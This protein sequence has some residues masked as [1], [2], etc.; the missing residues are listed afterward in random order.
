MSIS[1]YPLLRSF[2]GALHKLFLTIPDNPT[3]KINNV[4]SIYK[5]LNVGFL[6]EKEIETYFGKALSCLEDISLPRENKQIMYD[7]VKQLLG[8]EL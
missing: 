7:V 3:E 2:P 5:D 4:L 6:V 1:R 8:R